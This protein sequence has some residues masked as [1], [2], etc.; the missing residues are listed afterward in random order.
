MQKISLFQQFILEI[1]SILE[2]RNKIEAPIFRHS[3]PKNYRSKFNIFE[4]VST[5][6]KS[7]YFIDLFWRFCLFKNTAIWLAINHFAPYLRNKILHQTDDLQYINTKIIKIFIIGQ[8]QQKLKIIF[9]I[10]WKKKNLSL[11]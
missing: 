8:I 3:D 1:H 9:L 7:G 4:S 2:S 10:K 11:A 6:K 5:L